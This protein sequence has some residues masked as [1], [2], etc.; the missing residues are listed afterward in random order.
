[1]DLCAQAMH[2][3]VLCLAWLLAKQAEAA[4]ALATVLRIA[5]CWHASHKAAA[6]FACQPGP[7]AA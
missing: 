4:F 5:Q 1:M 2:A 3:E 6:L 7:F